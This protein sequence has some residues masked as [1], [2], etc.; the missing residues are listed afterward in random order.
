MDLGGGG[1][2][3]SQNAPKNR[4]K[5]YNLFCLMYLARKCMINLRKLTVKF[6]SQQTPYKMEVV[7]KK[8]SNISR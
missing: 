3:T 8:T 1:G 7:Q 5:L 6:K 4:V 2:E